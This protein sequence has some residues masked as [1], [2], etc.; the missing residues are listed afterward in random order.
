VKFA[1]KS[2]IYFALLVSLNDTLDYWCKFEKIMIES[3]GSG[4]VASS[5]M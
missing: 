5:S 4:S 2:A 3:S 1:V